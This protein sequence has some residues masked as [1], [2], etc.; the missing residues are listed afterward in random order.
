L[1]GPLEGTPLRG[2]S[3]GEALKRPSGAAERL[4]IGTAFALPKPRR[5][6]V[7]HLGGFSRR[8]GKDALRTGA[9]G[10]QGKTQEDQ[11]PTVGGFPLRS[12]LRGLLAGKGPR[13][14]GVAECASILKNRTAGGRRV[15]KKGKKVEG[16][17]RLWLA[18]PRG[19]FPT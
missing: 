3:G 5:K 18:D 8:V 7:H 2:E 13:K 14:S 19:G 15:E 4:L 10:G 6:A 12:C 1:G 16:V 9:V 17:P 11:S